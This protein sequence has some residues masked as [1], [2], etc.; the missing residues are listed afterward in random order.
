MLKRRSSLDTIFFVLP[1][2]FFS[3]GIGEEVKVIPVTLF[4]TNPLKT[5]LEA[6]AEAAKIK[7]VIGSMRERSYFNCIHHF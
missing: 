6:A 7:I 5:I 2:S 3:L 4:H 1:Y